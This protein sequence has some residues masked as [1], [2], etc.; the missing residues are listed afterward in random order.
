MGIEGGELRGGG[1]EG[2]IG[3]ELR[4]IEGRGNLGGELRGGKI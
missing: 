1:I 2:G 3:G 4:G